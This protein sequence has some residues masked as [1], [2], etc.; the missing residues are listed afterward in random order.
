MGDDLPGR[1][2]LL[3]LAEI[4]RMENTAMKKT[5]KMSRWWIQPAWMAPYVPLLK[6]TGGTFNDPAV[7][8]N[9]DARNCNL[10]VNAP[11]AVL[12]IAVQSQVRLLESLHARGMLMEPTP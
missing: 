3:T 11:R 8:M 4:A 5:E 10:A 9:C 7:A 12:C 2:T 6:N 1:A